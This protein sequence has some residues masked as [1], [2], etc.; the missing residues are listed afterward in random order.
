[1][2][3]VDSRPL[4]VRADLSEGDLRRVKKGLKGKAKSKALPDLKLEANVREVSTAPVAPGKF[5]LVVDVPL[6]KDADAILPG[7]SCKLEFVVYEN[8]DA[9]VVPVS[10]VFSEEDD[11][12]AKYVY[13]HRKGKK[14]KKQSVKVGK[15]SGD[16]WEILEGIRSGKE[17]LAEKPKK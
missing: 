17:I 1:M 5:D 12:D 15:K 2:T 16:K 9:L 10:A 6:P 14:P 11:E 3:I 7:M 4:F 13:L 8:K